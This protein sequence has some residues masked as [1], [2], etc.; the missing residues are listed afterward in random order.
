MLLFLKGT[1]L[2]NSAFDYSLTLFGKA[3]SLN[4]C[5]G[6][7]STFT[8]VNL[9]HWYNENYDYSCVFISFV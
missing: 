6:L 9:F 7:Q 4:L 8:V 5:Y 3:K 1:H 2:Q